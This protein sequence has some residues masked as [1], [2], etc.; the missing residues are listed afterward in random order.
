MRRFI[1]SLFLCACVSCSSYAQLTWS[2]SSYPFTSSRG[3]RADFT[4]DGFSDLIFFD[5]TAT[6]LT[7]LPNAG[8]GSF[9]S[10]KAFT[11]NQQGDMALLD[12]NRDG[13]TD[14]ALC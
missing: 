12:F 1:A 13:K 6:K 10:S 3:E 11:T 9:N 5:H 8:N 7:V 2:K 4:G 14:V